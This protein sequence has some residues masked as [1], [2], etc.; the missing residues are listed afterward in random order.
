MEQTAEIQFGILLVLF[1]GFILVDTNSSLPMNV[2][3]LIMVIGLFIGLDGV[4][5]PQ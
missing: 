2:E 3:F 4:I 1:G 5:N